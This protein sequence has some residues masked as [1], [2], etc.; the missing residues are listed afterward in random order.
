[1]CYRSRPT[2]SI[3][4]GMIDKELQKLF[5]GDFVCHTFEKLK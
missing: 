1:M 2:L 5:D 4:V 3:G